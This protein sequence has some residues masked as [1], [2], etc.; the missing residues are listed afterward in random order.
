[1]FD[2]ISPFIAALALAMTVSVASA[3][4]PQAGDVPSGVFSGVASGT[5]LAFTI[6]STSA[7]LDTGEDVTVN[8]ILMNTNGGDFFSIDM[9]VSLT[10]GS[11]RIFH[12]RSLVTGG[13]NPNTGDA[14]PA[15]D[16]STP[17]L[18]LDTYVSNG[19]HAFGDGLS[20][21]GGSAILFPGAVLGS[22]AAARGFAIAE[23]DDL[24]FNVNGIDITQ[25]GPS[26]TD[27][28]VAQITVLTSSNGFWE[29]GITTADADLAVGG[30]TITNGVLG[31]PGA[32]IPLPAAAWL[33]MSLLGGIGILRFARR[34]L[35]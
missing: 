2:R 19:D 12:T 26:G 4:I 17:N 6:D 16:T 23:E 5:G 33:G 35:A 27:L 7:Q 32:V 14:P 28:V 11:G 21:S 30:G 9:L 10:S 18:A 31:L 15:F 1:M 24:V 25:P 34:R 29:L 20:I 8:Q 13:V 22:G 3:Q